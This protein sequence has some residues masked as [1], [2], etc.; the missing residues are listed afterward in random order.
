MII[1]ATNLILGRLAS[2]AAK[3]ALLGEDIKIVNCE[4]AIISGNKKYLLE[5]YKLK[6]DKGV[7]LKGPYFPRMPDRIVRRTVRGMLPY[8][9]QRG[10]DAYKKIMCYM[11]IPEELSKENPVT[12]KEA[13]ASKL[14]TMKFITVGRISKHLG[15]KI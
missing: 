4:K 14:P 10:R 13:D 7:P 3:K 1:D 12:L 9:K 15:A 5:K 8:K 6:F 11:G 2:F